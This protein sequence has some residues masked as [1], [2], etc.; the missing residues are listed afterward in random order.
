MN[1]WTQLDH[2]RWEIRESLDTLVPETENGSSFQH[3]CGTNEP[4]PVMA[5]TVARARPGCAIAREIQRRLRPSVRE[6]LARME[7]CRQE[8]S[9]LFTRQRHALETIRS[10]C[11]SA[12]QCDPQTFGA[13]R[14]DLDLGRTS[15]DVR[16]D[17][18]DS[19]TITRW[20]GL[21]LETI[22][23]LVEVVRP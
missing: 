2:P 10:L 21:N 14:L 9:A 6:S 5:I 3:L 17:D 15:L 12:H 8:R 11:S 23:R 18:S 20:S 19:I 4:N 7:A 16:I 22:L 1:C 13:P